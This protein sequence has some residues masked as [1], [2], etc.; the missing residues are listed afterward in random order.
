M[1]IFD[2]DTFTGTTGTLLSAHAPGTG[3]SWVIA[4]GVTPTAQLTSAG[5]VRSSAASSEAD[6]LCQGT[7]GSADYVVQADLWS[8]SSARSNYAGVLARADANAGASAGGNAYLG[9]YDGSALAWSIQKAVG[10]SFTQVGTAFSATLTASTTTTFKLTLTGTSLVL[11]VAGTDRVTATDSAITTTGKAG[12]FI[13]SSLVT[14]A[15]SLELD[16]FSAT[17]A[18]AASIFPIHPHA[19]RNPL[20]PQ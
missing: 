5:R 1:A 11:N 6:Y 9:Q 17:D 16:N 3:G 13:S 18:S 14:D 19:W 10:G 12:I 8:G 20:L 15:F 4:T 2:N 7:P